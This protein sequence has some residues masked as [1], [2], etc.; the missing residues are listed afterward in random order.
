MST[1]KETL[2][3]NKAFLVTGRRPEDFELIREACIATLLAE[4]EEVVKDLSKYLG[5]KSILPPDYHII[6]GFPGDNQVFII[7]K[8]PSL[9]R[10]I[11]AYVGDL[12][13]KYKH[14]KP[15]AFRIG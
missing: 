14:L 13:Q 1:F 7:L 12:E 5:S 10:Q 3:L 11:V 6:E 15:Y 4:N 2:P 9:R 8:S